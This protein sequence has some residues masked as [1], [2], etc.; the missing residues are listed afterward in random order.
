MGILQKDSSLTLEMLKLLSDDLKKA[1]LQITHLAQKPVRDRVAEAILFIKETYGFEADG[2]TIDA[3]FSRE[4]MANI[5]GTATE[6]VI[7][8]LSEFNKEGVIQVNAKKITIL[9]LKKLVHIANIND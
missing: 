5:V 9:N 2:K 4:D 3:S 1:E 7:R 8:I 6:T